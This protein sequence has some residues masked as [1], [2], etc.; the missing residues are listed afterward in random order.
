MGIFKFTNKEEAKKALEETEI[1][2]YE[3]KIEK[4]Q[5]LN[6]NLMSEINALKFEI[7][8]ESI[9]VEKKEEEKELSKEEMK[10][11]LDKK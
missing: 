10:E 11:I 7:H 8:T 1:K 9:P 3:L 2:N 4:Y 6:E 5:K